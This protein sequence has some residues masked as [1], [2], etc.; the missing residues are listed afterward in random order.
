MSQDSEHLQLLAIFHYVVAGLAALLSFLP[1][2]YSGSYFT[3]LGIRVR[4]ISNRRLHFLA[5]SLLQWAQFS[6]SQESSWRSAS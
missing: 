6:L 5:G 3:P 4:V 1:L 2:F